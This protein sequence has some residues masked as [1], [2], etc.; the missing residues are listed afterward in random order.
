MYPP[1]MLLD[2][3]T[4]L[5]V[6]G[7]SESLRRAPGTDPQAALGGPASL[8]VGCGHGR[9]WSALVAVGVAA[10]ALRRFEKRMIFYL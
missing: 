2:R 5:D 4:H 9:C 8:A 6:A 7:R 3:P 1:E 10:L